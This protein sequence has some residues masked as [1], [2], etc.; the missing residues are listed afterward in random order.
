[1][2]GDIEELARKYALQNAVEH[3]GRANAGPVIGKVMAA[4]PDWRL[5]PG[6]VGEAVNTTVSEVNALSLD[7]QRDELERL[8]PELLVKEKKEKVHE[9]PD[10]EGAEGGVVMRLAPN[11]SGP[12]HIGHTRMAILNDIYVKRYGGRLIV[13]ME[14]TNPPTILPEAYDLILKDLD[15]LG[16]EYHEVVNQ[17][18]RFQIYYDHAMKLLEGGNAYMCGCPSDDWRAAKEQGMACPCR[19]AG[20]RDNLGLWER[21]LAGEYKPGEMSMIVKTDLNHPNPAVRD[22]VALRLVGEPH[23]LT[24]DEF[25]VY[26]LYNYSVAIDDHLM[27]MTHVLRGKDHLNNTLRQE[28]VYEHL[29][30]T[31][32]HFH[33]YGWVSIE[34]TELSTRKI[35]A[36]IE[37]ARYSGWKD[38]RLGTVAALERRGIQPEAIRQYWIDVGIKGVDIRF[39]WENLY[40][41]NKDIVDPGAKRYFFVW[42]PKTVSIT[43][44]DVLESHAPLHPEHQEMGTRVTQLSGD[45]IHVKA[46]AGDIQA[47]PP[48]TRVRF[49][50]LCNTLSGEPGIFSYAG[51]EL[52]FI[53]EG[54]KIIHW[55]GP[56]AV[57]AKVLMPDGKLIEG[58]A[59]KAALDS[60]GEVVQFERFGF[61]RLEP[62]DE[63]EAYFAHQ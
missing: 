41:Y 4:A 45:P 18:S 29:G 2:A 56:D 62:G 38:P 23:P 34:D 37:E 46:V 42:D 51:N 32:P 40:A 59:E 14:D 1:M 17:S 58:L 6:E 26:P 53:K 7:A 15:W 11:P 54:A 20:P 25:R 28:Y 13:R 55:V 47:L 9:L 50:D 12:L 39:S 49:K 5:K 57:Q 8:A 19:D 10:L 24:G 44:T 27:G 60:L 30:W 22:F 48:D 21:M 63:I 36:A 31:K 16:V 3:G 33:H 43:G 61:V 35:R 52:S